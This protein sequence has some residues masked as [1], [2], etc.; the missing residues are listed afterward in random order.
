[1]SDWDIVIIARD[2]WGDVWRRRHCLAHEWARERRVLFVEP[3]VK[4]GRKRGKSSVD[5]RQEQEG[6]PHGVR[7]VEENIYVFRPVKRVPTSVSMG[8]S[9]TMKSIAGSIK[10]ILEA[11]DFRNPVLWITAEYGVH[12]IDRV[13]HSLVIYDVTDDWTQADLPKKEMKQIVADDRLLADRAG[14]IFTVSKALFDRKSHNRDNVY[15]VPNGVRIEMYESIEKGP[16]RELE[17]INRPIVGYTGSLHAGRLDVKLID[18]VAGL[19]RGRF[20]LAFIGPNSLDDAA[21]STLEKHGNVHISPPAPFERMPA[22][23]A[24]FDLCCIPHTVT[25]FTNSLNPLKAFEYLASGSPIISTPV[26][27]M[28][29]FEEYVTFAEG[30]AEFFESALDILGGN[31]KSTPEERKA[32]AGRHSWRIREREIRKIID[33]YFV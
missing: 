22:I 7:K 33:E 4:A 1:M 21:Q 19:A 24:A 11:L 5:S 17:A 28:L 9:L 32:A 16:A 23:L 10:K 14:I 8:R 25:P 12:F 20:S 26:A 15:I 30:P 29:P 27:E 3:A 2:N 13:P 6:L 18:K 31:E